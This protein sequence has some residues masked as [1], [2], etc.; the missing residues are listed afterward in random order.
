MRRA[1]DGGHHKPQLGHLLKSIND[2]IVD[3]KINIRS[4]QLSCEHCRILTWEVKVMQTPVKWRF[5]VQEKQQGLSRQHL[6]WEGSRA[7]RLV[8]IMQGA[9]VIAGPWEGAA[10]SVP[11]HLAV[12]KEVL[13]P[14]QSNLCLQPHTG[15]RC[16]LR[17]GSGTPASSLEQIWN[18]HLA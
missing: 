8:S 11:L 9:A 10:E 6:E 13:L 12:S 17:C 1:G 2:S 18:S 3:G 4:Q 7:V 16:T 5:L 14:C 15:P